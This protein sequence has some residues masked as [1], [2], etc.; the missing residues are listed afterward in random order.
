M[1]KSLLLATALALAGVTV[2]VARPAERDTAPEQRPNEA[3]ALQGMAIYSSDGEKVGRVAGVEFGPDGSVM[4]IKAEIDGFLGL[5][6]L[7]VTI[8]SRQFEH[9][10]D[11]IVLSQ[12][13]DEVRGKPRLPSPQSDEGVQRAAPLPAAP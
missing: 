7:N 8:F 9:D 12:T 11:R 6:T 13:A 5:E 4:A 1:C 3:K 10:Q 2:G